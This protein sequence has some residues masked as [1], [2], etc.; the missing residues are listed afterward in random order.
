MLTQNLYFD[1]SGSETSNRIDL[2][3]GNTAF[4]NGDVA[5]FAI[6]SDGKL[7]VHRNG[8]YLKKKMH[9]KVLKKQK[10]AFL[11]VNLLFFLQ[12]LFME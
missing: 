2:T 7:F 12:K 4:S 3:S 6:L 9:K 1:I 10:N 5:G 11:E 8:T